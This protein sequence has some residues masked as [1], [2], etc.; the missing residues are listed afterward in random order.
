LK[1]F[2]VLILACFLFFRTSLHT[3]FNEFRINPHYTTNE[4]LLF[5]PNTPRIIAST[6]FTTPFPEPALYFGWVFSGKMKNTYSN[7]LEK[8]HPH[9]YFYSVPGNLYYGWKAGEEFILTDLLAK[10]A[11]M[12]L[13][14]RQTDNVC[15]K[16]IFDAIKDINLNATIVSTK[17]VF[18][19]KDNQDVI[20]EINSDTSKM[21]SLLKLQNLIVCDME[22]RTADYTMFTSNTKALFTG[23]LC[24]T[25]EKAYDGKHGVLLNYEDQY[26][27]QT[28]F[29]ANAGNTY[30]ISIWKQSCCN[31]LNLVVTS[32]KGEFYK[33]STFPCRKE[34]PWEELKLKFIL[35]HDFKIDSLKAY[36]WNTKDTKTILDNMKIKEFSFK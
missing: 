5:Y 22:S 27:L 18:R 19:N 1:A 14:I 3:N 8:L 16:I 35:P 7:T 21:A 31:D 4:F 10:N 9:S 24:I 17:E 34:G 28:T 15:E 23:G 26:A 6:E 12:L 13:Y 30:E 2:A 25:D 11:K 32:S 29:K 20:Y 36:V 33:M